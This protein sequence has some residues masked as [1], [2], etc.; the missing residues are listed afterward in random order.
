[1]IGPS[2]TLQRPPASVVTGLL[3]VAATAV[4][5]GTIE[6]RA[7]RTAMTAG[8]WF[9]DGAFDVPANLLGE[10][11]GPFSHHERDAIERTARHELERAFDGLRIVFADGSTGFW[12]VEVVPV[13]R[14]GGRRSLGAAG[15]SLG[16]GPLG[17][18]ASIGMAT[19]VGNALRHAPE[20]ATREIIVEGIGR[21][22]GRSA[23]H[24]LAHQIAAVSIDNR[25]D[26][27]S[28]EY[29]SAD[30]PAQYYGELR[31]ATAWPLLKRK[32]GE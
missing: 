7:S 32:L 25:T 26:R 30:R 20:G 16:F 24:E 8:F 27:E 15:F 10:L 3:A 14:L 4:V 19:I 29:F 18:R 22:V 21:G 5:F 11:G 1:M 6:W 2:M 28:Y 31:W 12:R 17:G 23:A 9:Q 13:I